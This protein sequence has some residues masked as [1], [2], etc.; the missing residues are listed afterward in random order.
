M[1]VVFFCRKGLPVQVSTDGPSVQ[2]G[3]HASH[4]Q[5]RQCECSQDRSRSRR[6]SC[7]NW[8]G[9]DTVLSKIATLSCST[10]I[11]EIVLRIF[12][13]PTPFDCFRQDNRSRSGCFWIFWR[14]ITLVEKA[15]LLLREVF[16]GNLKGCSEIPKRRNAPQLVQPR[17]KLQ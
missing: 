10:V 8:L 2:G 7:P 16:R 9:T 13:G 15:S 1:Y 12:C 5:S 4:H 11:W 14:T 6:P 3:S 17:E